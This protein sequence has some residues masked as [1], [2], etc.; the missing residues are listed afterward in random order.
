MVFVVLFPICCYAPSPK[1]SPGFLCPVLVDAVHRWS[2]G[3]KKVLLG[4]AVPLGCEIPPPPQLHLSFAVKSLST[5]LTFNKT[6]RTPCF[7]GILTLS[8]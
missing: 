1:G 2:C 5:A 4:R 6:L 7:A 8:Y 3:H